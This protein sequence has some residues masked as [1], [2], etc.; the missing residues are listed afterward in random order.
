MPIKAA[1]AVKPQTGPMANSG[2]STLLPRERGAYAQLGIALLAG[3]LLGRPGLRGGAQVLLTVL[4]FLASEPAR[5]LLAGREQRRAWTRLALLGALGAGSGWLAWHGAPV[6]L[7]PALAL[8]A[9]LAALLSGFL[10]LGREHTPAGEWV[11][12]WALASAAYAP[13]LLGGASIGQALALTILLGALLS[14]GMT[15]AR[16]QLRGWAPGLALLPAAAF[17]AL[18]LLAAWAGWIPWSSAPAVLPM[19][20]AAALLQLRPAPNLRRLGWLLAGAS[21]LGAALA[22]A[23]LR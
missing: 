21:A 2:S 14:A 13:A 3:L 17:T 19:A 22:V 9:A 5:A 7:L 12:A 16:A 6:P 15:V 1:P 20:L 10:V 8:P 23:G 18:S 4:V 11:S